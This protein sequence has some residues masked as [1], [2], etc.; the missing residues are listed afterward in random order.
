MT[1]VD[2]FH[3]LGENPYHD[4]LESSVLTFTAAG[5]L[6]DQTLAE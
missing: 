4:R 3:G 6:G 5:K 1:S 2:D